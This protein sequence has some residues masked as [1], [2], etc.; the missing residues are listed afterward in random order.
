MNNNPRNTKQ[1]TLTDQTNTRLYP[2]LQ[3]S[4]ST[5][6]PSL[7]ELF[8]LISNNTDSKLRSKAF[9]RISSK[10]S[11]SISSL[12]LIDEIHEA[13]T[14][15]Y[16][17]N[18]TE[19]LDDWLSLIIRDIR[20]EI[21][22]Y[23]PFINTII[24]SPPALKS[25]LQGCLHAVELLLSKQANSNFL[26]SY[27]PCLYDKADPSNSEDPCVRVIDQMSKLCRC[28]ILQSIL[29]KVY[30]STTAAH[31]LAQK[32]KS[33]R[34]MLYIAPS[35]SELQWE[36][37]L[38][39]LRAW[40]KKIA[41]HPRLLAIFNTD[42]RLASLVVKNNCINQELSDQQIS[43]KNEYLDPVFDCRHDNKQ[44][45]RYVIIFKRSLKF[46]FEY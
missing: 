7:H 44:F 3:F 13:Y 37:N 33:L 45:T 34:M 15:G 46:K 42:T 6:E 14:N 23:Q 22:F 10:I 30:Q 17:T 39:K 28:D 35:I 11:R 16:N 25:K 4:E 32:E 27:V 24:Q 26:I 12:S 8:C 36:N 40:A 19:A 38:F 29:D 9:E 31:V 1:D 5:E 2:C 21:D 20:P 43:I 18:M 41:F